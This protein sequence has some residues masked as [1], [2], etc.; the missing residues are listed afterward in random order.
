MVAK[1][2][3]TSAVQQQI[4]QGLEEAAVDLQSMLKSPVRFSELH[5]EQNLQLRQRQHREHLEFVGRQAGDLLLALAADNNEG[6][7]TQQLAQEIYDELAEVVRSHVQGCL[8][9]EA[10]ETWSCHLSVPDRSVSADIRLNLFPE[11][12]VR[13]G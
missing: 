1:Q 5:R 3:Q 9:Q 8:E 10:A 2:E 11:S 12:H 6:T 4:R 13:M 7:S